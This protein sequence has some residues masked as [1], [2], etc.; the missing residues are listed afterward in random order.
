MFQEAPTFPF[1]PTN[2][3]NEDAPTAAM[4][5][6][7]NSASGGLDFS[8]VFDDE[9]QDL[10]P[11]DSFLPDNAL[12]ALNNSNAVSALAATLQNTQNFPA[13]NA[14]A[15]LTQTPAPTT[16]Q[17]DAA[18]QQ[19]FV[20]VMMIVDP[21]TG[22]VVCPKQVIACAIGGSVQKI[23]FG[24]TVFDKV[25]T[26]AEV[27]QRILMTAAT[28]ANISTPFSAP[29]QPHSVSVDRSTFKPISPEVPS[30]ANVP[31]LIDTTP[32]RV[33]PSTSSVSSN[34]YTGSPNDKGGNSNAPAILQS[35]LRALSA[36]NF[37]FRDERDRIIHDAEHDWSSDKQK[38]LLADHWTRDRTKKRRHRKTHGKIDF[39]TLSKLISSRWKELSKEHKEFY[40]QVAAQDWERYQRELAEYKRLT[41]GSNM[42]SP[43]LKTF[44]TVVA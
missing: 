43:G 42:S 7:H 36:Y 23:S 34:S 9:F 16:I 35:P 27:T 2:W 4:N 31:S 24:P 30:V 41:N 1:A 11:T 17:Q 5:S 32:G 3:A 44:Q 26:G 38:K 19:P 22:K 6:N 20:N 39:T 28:S 29:T 21:A 8:R 10:F 33:S 37:F 25:P 12:N 13:T 15:S 40:R 18:Q 14:Q